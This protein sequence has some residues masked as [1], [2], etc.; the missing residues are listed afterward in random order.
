MEGSQKRG[1]GRY[2][3]INRDKVN[4]IT[5][6]KS[7]TLLLGRYFACSLFDLDVP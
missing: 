6:E 4:N 3:K 1:L 5:H 2:S 7:L